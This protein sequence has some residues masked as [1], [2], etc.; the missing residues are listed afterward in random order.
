DSFR[1]KLRDSQLDD[2]EVEIEL[3]G[4]P[5]SGLPMFEIPGMPGASMGAVNLGDMFGKAFGAAKGKP[6]RMSV[7]DAYAPLLAEES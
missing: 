4:N 5:S 6:R 7:R 2:K 3:A 1:K